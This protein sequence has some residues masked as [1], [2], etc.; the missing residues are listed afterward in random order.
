M[1][2]KQK[3]IDKQTQDNLRIIDCLMRTLSSAENIALGNIKYKKYRKY[4]DTDVCS[5]KKEEQI[6][7]DFIMNI[8]CL[9]TMINI[10]KKRHDNK[11]FKFPIDQP[12]ESILYDL[13]NYKKIIGQKHPKLISYCDD[14]RKL[15]NGENCKRYTEKELIGSYKNENVEIDENKINKIGFNILN[16]TVL[17]EKRIKK[18]LKKYERQGEIVED[19]EDN[20]CDC[21]DD[22]YEYYY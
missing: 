12:K 20:N 14:L 8:E 6:I 5:W 9:N 4:D 13:Q 18:K 19:L 1:F 21:S 11:T 16:G 15:I 7:D 10:Y 17:E 22:E 2:H 3:V